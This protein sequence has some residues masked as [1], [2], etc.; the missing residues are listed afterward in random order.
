MLEGPREQELLRAAATGDACSIQLVVQSHLRLVVKIAA[1]YQRNEL[2]PD[3]LVSEGVVGLIEALRRYDGAY[4][5]RFAGYAA[6]W[7]RARVGQYA[8]ANRRIVAPPSTRGGRRAA[9]ELHK[10]DQRLA[11]TLDRPP[12]SDEL[13]REM[14][15]SVGDV[16]DARA[17]FGAADLPIESSRLAA[18]SETPEQ[19][20]ASRELQEL[21]QAQV[22]KALHFLS[23]REQLLIREQYLE[24]EGRTLGELGDAFGVSRQRLGQVLANARQKLRTSLADSART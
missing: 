3:D 11:R 13:A 19:L 5:A 15:V 7:I 8:A 22:R 4:G 2:A 14:C 1:R 18:E 16:E 10:A 6:W 17:V 24:E 12:S 21:R 20:V 9:R 23:E